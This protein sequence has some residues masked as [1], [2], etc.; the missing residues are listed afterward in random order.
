MP[1]VKS[2]RALK[3][4]SKTGNVVPYQST[5]ITVN[6]PQ[7]PAVKVV[8]SEYHTWSDIANKDNTL[9]TIITEYTP[10]E[11]GINPILFVVPKAVENLPDLSRSHI[12][13]LVSATEADRGAL[14]A[15]EVWFKNNAFH[16]IIKS[17]D[18][19]LNATTVTVN[20]D[21][22]HQEVYVTT[23]LNHGQEEQETFLTCQ[24]WA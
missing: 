15:D 12:I 16:T 17:V 10:K 3:T 11:T 8:S 1:T 7:A 23:L 6:Q 24:G 13:F 22:Y 21:L 2:S 19:E 4:L 18:I 9:D 20:S 5:V 14:G